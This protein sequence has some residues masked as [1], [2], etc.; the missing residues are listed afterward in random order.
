MIIR[1]NIKEFNN[2][3]DERNII[4]RSEERF[5]SQMTAV[6]EMIDRSGCRAILLSG[7]S[8]SGKTTAGKLICE[9][10]A[11]M[12]KKVKEVSFDDFYY[13]NEYL[14][15]R[16]EELNIPFD[17]DSVATIDLKCIGQCVSDIYSGKTAMLPQFSF[18]QGK[19]VG[20]EEFKPDDDFVVL[21]EGIQAV[22]PEVRALFSG[23]KSLFVYITAISE[24]E[25][26][27]ELFTP[28]E[29][30]FCRRLVRDYRDRCATPEYTYTHWKGVT[31]NEDINILPYADDSDIKIDST[32]EYEPY[33]IKDKALEL[34]SMI[35]KD[36]V[37]KE[38]ADELSRKFEN[39]PSMSAK[40]LPDGSC[41]REFI[42][43]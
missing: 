37:Y 34:L 14:I 32:F 4:D 30:R 21:F 8:C 5:V 20:Y 39:I 40:F 9:H 35:E 17:M 23:I 31:D 25:V 3:E 36:S 19:R 15:K 22:Y 18:A 43:R 1:S 28:R 16:C 27:G 24:L 10:L 6:C 42:G 11:K 7:P 33:M 38:K 29:L 41:F 2:T 26:N 12:G 13:N